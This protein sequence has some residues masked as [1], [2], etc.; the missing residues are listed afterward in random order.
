VAQKTKDKA[1]SEEELEEEVVDD[2][3]EAVEVIPFTYT[4]TS[5]G[6]DYP[7]D[8]LIKRIAAKDIIVPVFGRQPTAGSPIIGF[9]RE[10]VWPRPKADRFIESLLLGLPVPGIFLVK[11]LSGVFL[12]LD[13]H[14]RLYT[15]Q[16]FYEGVIQGQEYRLENVQER[17]VG[18]RYKD[19]DAEDRRRIDDS[20]IHATIVR[21]DEP[22]ED[23]SS[24]YIVFER[25]NTG[26][27]NLQPQ[28]IRVALYHGELVRVLK[29]LNENPDWRA[30]FGVKSKR[31]KD[32]ELILRFFAF[33][34]H[35]SKY[36]SPMKDFLNRYMATNRSLKR[37]SEKELSTLFSQTVLTIR[38]GI[39]PKAFR[40]IR[41]VNAAVVDSLMTGVA[42]R[43]SD[44][45]P[46]KSKAQFAQFRRQ[47]ER[48]LNNKNYL[49]A[50]E[51]GT[52]QEANVETRL[53][54][55]QETFRGIR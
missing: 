24:I 41:A 37:Q 5:Y 13:G 52:S 23:Q 45:G 1:R 48:L 17:F 42:K 44:R 2:L 50:V 19:L 27:V 12:V 36:R 34:Y 32:M 7:V 8:G 25:L 49:G 54:L 35:A 18:L 20:I 28:E 31:L 51:T 6:A 26:G 40:P 15:L 55:A 47:Y 16:A 30:L 21:Q 4:I 33:Y 9:Q 22:S 39:G 11:E 29:E 14:Q 46:L 3:D 10:Y 43:I 53:R 38:K